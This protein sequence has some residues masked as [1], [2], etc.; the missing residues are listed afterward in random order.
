MSNN[1][2]N[3]FDDNQPN[4]GNAQGA[5]PQKKS[6]VWLWVLGIIGVLAVGGAV[7]CCGG[8]YF[9]YRAGTGMM[10]DIFKEQLVGNP[11]IEEHIGTI[12][13]MS[14][15]LGATTENAENSPGSI[16]FDIGG[17]KGSG[18]ILIQQQQGADG[19]PG[20][21]SAE[22]IL[23]DGSRHAIDIADSPAVIDDDFKID[24]GQPDL[25]PAGSL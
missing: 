20:I 13:S 3:P 9:A 5:P 21:G 23:E 25:E 22:L 17:S 19:Q 24:L 15:N 14:M 18:T 4:Q 11:V 7:F 16:A 6:N 8:G 1:P 2:N 12:E 10:A